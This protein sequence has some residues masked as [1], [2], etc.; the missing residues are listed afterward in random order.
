MN[1]EVMY[2]K[3][4][5]RTDRNGPNGCWLFVGA[6]NGT[7]YGQIRDENRK[8]HSAHRLA[9]ERAKGLLGPGM[10]AC[11]HCDNPQ[12]VNPDH[13]FAGTHR[14]N[15][16]DAGRK[17][18]IGGPFVPRKSHCARGHEF[19]PE[20]TRTVKYGCRQCKTCQRDSQRRKYQERTSRSG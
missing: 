4:D 2:A 11:H 16:I 5:A 15:M 3:L 10:C 8:H 20:N 13:L 9:L 19:T 12:C 17:G 7:G 6:S 1:R 18:K 14:D